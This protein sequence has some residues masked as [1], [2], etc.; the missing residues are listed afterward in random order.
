MR[1]ISLFAGGLL[2]TACGAVVTPRVLTPVHCV[3]QTTGLLTLPEVESALGSSAT[4]WLAANDGSSPVLG[5]WGNGDAFYPGFVGRAQR[6]FQHSEQGRA[7][8]AQLFHVAVASSDFGSVQ[9]AQK[10]LANQRVM[11]IPNDKPNERN[12]VETIPATVTIGDDTFA[13][14]LP[15]TSEGVFTDIESRVGP[16]LLAVSTQSS[17]TY[18]ALSA[19]VTLMTS[20]H[21]KEHAVCG[22]A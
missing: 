15:G 17:P 11:N 8:A 13:Y 22:V 20:L 10:W 14:Q 2:L 7:G 9:M 19:V 16:Y 4:G 21:A 5:L 18:D 12:G 1:V 6:D 3:A